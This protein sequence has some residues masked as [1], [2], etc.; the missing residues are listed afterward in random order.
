MNDTLDK[1]VKNFSDLDEK[2]HVEVE[3]RAEKFS[4]TPEYLAAN[5]IMLHGSNYPTHSF[6]KNFIFS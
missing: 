3:D 4:D 1:P 2:F 5:Y 6:L